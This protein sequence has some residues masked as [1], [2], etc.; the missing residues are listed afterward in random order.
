MSI[1]HENEG[2]HEPA[3]ALMICDRDELMVL[4]GSYLRIRGEADYNE[5]E[6]HVSWQVQTLQTDLIRT[7]KSG[8]KFNA[9]QDLVEHMRFILEE[10]LTE[11]HFKKLE[12]RLNELPDDDIN[13]TMDS[14]PYREMAGLILQYRKVSPRSLYD[15]GPIYQHHEHIAR[16]YESR[17][18]TH[19]QGDENY[20][21]M[22]H[23]EVRPMKRMLQII[24]EN[25]TS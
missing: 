25:T 6:E 22:E 3:G 13:A 1:L 14:V 2:S 10:H 20:S 18:I 15:D 7:E 4:T 23:V 8:S 16:W 24:N 19:N 11:P 12:A 9:S 5:G 17:L 21:P